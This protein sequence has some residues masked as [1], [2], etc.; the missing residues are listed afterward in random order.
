M[1]MELKTAR[2]IVEDIAKGLRFCG[3]ALDLERV[4]DGSAFGCC[5][6]ASGGVLATFRDPPGNRLQ[7]VQRPS[8]A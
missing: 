7:I 2:V 6:F 3:R 5:V 8:T 1:F 4:A